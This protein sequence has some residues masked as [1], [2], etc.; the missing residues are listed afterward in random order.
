MV[1]SGAATSISA[2]RLVP[3]I[4]NEADLRPAFRKLRV[5]G[6]TIKSRIAAPIAVA[7]AAVLFFGGCS[8]RRMVV[9]EFT[10]MVH[11]GMDAIEQEDD[12]FLLAQAMPAHI[13]LLETLLA[14]APH[15]RELLVLLAR[16]YGG[17]AFAILET[18]SEARRLQRPSVVQVG[19]DDTRLEEAIGRYFATG[20]QYAL[21][22]LETTHP[23]AAGE[24]KGL[25]SSRAFIQSLGKGD[26]PALFWYGFNLGGYVQH[27][28]DSV[29]AMA[30]AHLVEKT[31]ARIV[32]VDETYYY[33]AAHLV[34]L[35]YYGARPP[36]MGGSPEK[37]REHW[38]RHR[39]VVPGPMGL[40][41]LYLARYV[42]VRTGTRS[43]FVRCLNAVERE[44]G[45][46]AAP[47]LLEKVAAVR[48]GLYLEAAD[49]FFD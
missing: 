39:M 43:T 42:L 10:S 12:L 32:Q 21:R 33:G 17:Y 27:R 31:M 9:G 4:E 29:T 5:T 22:A 7:M 34:L 40:R 15:N 24:L 48:A 46:G 28:L 6:M 11:T 37:A 44:S 1:V 25:Q 19:L 14:S 38:E 30:Q 35:A 45:K 20:A 16:L 8:P 26:V 47:G 49:T 3:S 36:M 23:D 41:D 13:K 2:G 18:E